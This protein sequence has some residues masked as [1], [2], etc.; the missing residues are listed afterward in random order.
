MV[1]NTDS[2]AERVRELI[3]AVEDEHYSDPSDTLSGYP[4]RTATSAL[5][6]AADVR[7][8]INE[9]IQHLAER[10]IANGATWAEVARALGLKNASSAHYLYGRSTG[11]SL[12]QSRD[13]K[14]TKQRD[15]MATQ[16]A[17]AL[18]EPVPGLSALEAGRRLGIDRRTVV[19]RALRG[20]IE[21][22]TI[23]TA[24]GNQAVRYLVP[25]TSSSPTSSTPAAP[26]GA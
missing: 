6:V 13:A 1:H 9:I 14:L 16:R 8:T 24:K 21:T 7:A 23:T 19:K 15:R 5:E 11:M 20:E 4:P 2:V 12:S 26:S 18:K 3:E 17:I 10:A 22:V 25:G